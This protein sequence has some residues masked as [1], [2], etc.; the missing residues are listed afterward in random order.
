MS[1]LKQL[2]TLVRFCQLTGLIPFTM[3]L[4]PKTGQFLRF[5]F[6]WRHYVTWYCL[7]L[8]LLQLTG[9]ATIMTAMRQFT[10]GEE[11]NNVETKL[12]I[13]VVILI[14]VAATFQFFT[15]VLAKTI[16][17]RHASFRKISAILK[18][19]EE[20]LLELPNCKNSVLRRTL[21][22]F[23]LIELMVR[24]H[25]FLQLFALIN[26]ITKF[27]DSIR[28]SCYCLPPFPW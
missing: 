4:D 28:M 11:F 5:A 14:G 15:I 17:L 27:I 23:F 16:V 10:N 18:K 2:G 13:S 26:R 1:T 8:F 19:V 6:S 25:I 24:R 20:H 9:F 12:P 7:G 3:E 22:G 21:F